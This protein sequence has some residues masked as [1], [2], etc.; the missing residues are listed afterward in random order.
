[1]N[2]ASDFWLHSSN[3]IINFGSILRSAF[4]RSTGQKS[5]LWSG[6]NARFWFGQEQCSN[7]ETH[8]K[9]T[10]SQFLDGHANECKLRCGY[11]RK[12]IKV[13]NAAK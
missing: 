9:I 10:S 6:G 5:G 1:M 7:P 2:N 12:K 13:H 11:Q 4:L 8:L 3:I